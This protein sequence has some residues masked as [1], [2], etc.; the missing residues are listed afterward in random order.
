MPS[1]RRPDADVHRGGSGRRLHRAAVNHAIQR[2]AKVGYADVRESLN[3][4]RVKD[5]TRLMI[6]RWIDCS[7][8]PGR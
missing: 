1:S 7:R 5:R 2:C 8:R 6:R 4:L 3:Q